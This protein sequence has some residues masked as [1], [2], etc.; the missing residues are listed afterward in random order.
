MSAQRYILVNGEKVPAVRKETRGKGFK[1]VPDPKY[2]SKK[3]R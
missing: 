1:F 3:K 2:K